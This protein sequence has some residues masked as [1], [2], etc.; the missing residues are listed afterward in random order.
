MVLGKCQAGVCPLF[1]GIQSAV[2]TAPKPFWG[3]KASG[4][5]SAKQPEQTD[6]GNQENTL[7]PDKV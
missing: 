4:Y 5:D 3:S 6:T 1:C 2:V 7:A